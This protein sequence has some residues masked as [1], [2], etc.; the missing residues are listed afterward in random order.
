MLTYQGNGATYDPNVKITED[1][2]PA[3]FAYLSQAPKKNA[4]NI[5]YCYQHGAAGA[6]ASIA[7]LKAVSTTGLTAG[8]ERIVEGIGT[9]VLTASARTEGFPRVVAPTTGTGFRWI[10]A[11]SASGSAGLTFAINTI[12]TLIYGNGTPGPIAPGGEGVAADLFTVPVTGTGAGSIGIAPGSQGWANNV[13]TAGNNNRYL[14]VSDITARLAIYQ[15]AT[16]ANVTARILPRTSHAGLPALKPSIGVFRYR[17]NGSA[18]PLAEALYSLNAGLSIDA[19]A[20]VTA[21]ELAHTI[22]W[23]SSQN[24]VIDCDSWTYWLH[25]YDEGYTNAMTPGVRWHGAN[26]TIS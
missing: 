23:T 1:G 22:S 18:A 19:S 26:V 15:G 11:A 8:T 4:D 17:H 14:A 7:A 3:A 2:E 10:L 20:N 16:L 5:A 9:Y 21:Y 24:N 13:V 25:M 12:P 6:L